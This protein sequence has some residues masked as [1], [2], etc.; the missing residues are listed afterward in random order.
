MDRTAAEKYK[1]RVILLLALLAAALVLGAALRQTDAAAQAELQQRVAQETVRFHVLAD[2]DSEEDQ[3]VK[4]AVRD[5]LLEE[6]PELFQEAEEKARS[7]DRKPERKGLGRA[8][9]SNSI[10]AGACEV[11][12]IAGTSGKQPWNMD[13]HPLLSCNEPSCPAPREDSSGPG[14]YPLRALRR[15]PLVQGLSKPHRQLVR[16]RHHGQSKGRT[17]P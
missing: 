7:R 14:A 15:L 3:R 16:P 13:R 9:G 6:V 17:N 2:S 12:W 1:D 11:P 10:W 5:R 4:L 8:Q